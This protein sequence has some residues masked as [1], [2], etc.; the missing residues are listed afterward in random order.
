MITHLYLCPIFLFGGL[1]VRFMCILVTV[2]H[3]L[4]QTFTGDSLGV[5]GLGQLAEDRKKELV[6]GPWSGGDGTE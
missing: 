4:S 3:L 5:G 1:K 6:W 2:L